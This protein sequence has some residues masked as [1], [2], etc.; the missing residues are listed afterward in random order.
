MALW[1]RAS[2]AVGLFGEGGG[3]EVER[4]FWMLGD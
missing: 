3:K 2:V 4:G 1:I